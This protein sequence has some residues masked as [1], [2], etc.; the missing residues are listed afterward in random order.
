MLALMGHVSRAMLERYSHIRIVAK[1]DA[2]AGMRLRPQGVISRVLPVNPPVAT[3]G[4]VI[5]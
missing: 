2:V 1:H 3:A 4:E 5:Q